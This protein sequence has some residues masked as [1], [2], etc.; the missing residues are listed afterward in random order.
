VA[1]LG[2]HR[3]WRDLKT[4]IDWQ[5]GIPWVRSHLRNRDAE[6]QAVKENIKRVQRALRSAGFYHGT[7]DGHMGKTTRR[8]VRRFQKQNQL[9]STGDVGEST[10]KILKRYL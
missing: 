8:A 1:M 9:P 5:F 4:L 3:L 10:W 6:K 2:S 7:L